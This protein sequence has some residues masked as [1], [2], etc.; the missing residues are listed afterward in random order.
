MNTAFLAPHPV[1]AELRKRRTHLVE[2]LGERM[3]EVHRIKETVLPPLFAEYDKHFRTLEIEL[4]QV[5]LAASELGR[6]EELFRLKLE[7]GEVLSAKMI[8]V[9]NT[10]VDREFARVRK[11]FYEA[12]EQTPEEREQETTRNIFRKVLLSTT[13]NSPNSTALLSK[14][15]TLMLILLSRILLSRILLSR[16]LLSRILLSRIQMQLLKSASILLHKRTPQVL[17]NSGIPPKKHINTRIYAT[18]KPCTTLFAW[19]KS[20]MMLR[21]VFRLRKFYA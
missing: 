20:A 21:L 1:V 14:N 15:F 11:R 3:R 10:I 9:V 17:T 6:R 7:R 18:C 13:R 16:I 5:T 8:E 19:K 4:Q 12:F 2:R